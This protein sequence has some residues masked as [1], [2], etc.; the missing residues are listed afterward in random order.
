MRI[1]N[2][3][4]AAMVDFEFQPGRLPKQLNEHREWE[5]TDGANPAWRESGGEPLNLLA[6]DYQQSYAW[7]WSEPDWLMPDEAP[8]FRQLSR[9]FVP[10]PKCHPEVTGVSVLL[11]R[12]LGVGVA[13]FWISD[14]TEWKN[15]PWKARNA[16]R[17]RE[18]Y[19]QGLV[20]A[21]DLFNDKKV[22]FGRNYV[23]LAV[24]LDEE[25]LT[26]FCKNNAD[27]VAPWLTAAYENE[28]HKY[29]ANLIN[30]ER[31]MSW[32][33]HECLFMRWTDALALYNL[34]TV[35]N[36]AYRKELC[37]KALSQDPGKQDT[38]D[39]EVEQDKQHPA[40]TESRDPDKDYRLHRNRAAQL[41]EHCVLARRIFRTYG[42]QIATLS[43]RTG[44][45]RSAPVV[46]HS[47]RRANAVLSSFNEAELDFVV[48]VPIRSIEAGELVRTAIERCAIQ[49]VIDETRRNYDLLDRRL[50]WVRGQWLAVLAVLVFIANTVITI[51]KR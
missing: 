14:Y 6:N 21:S 43:T 46:S 49:S 11:L 51:L 18:C 2:V 22:S 34:D 39:D 33:Q 25:N 30:P 15:D 31:N 1:I 8:L 40:E 32:R 10:A 50:Q 17:R 29:R 37:R 9:W 7:L 19:W 42:Q 36:E 24:R 47:W 27:S 20:A 26:A 44:I 38:A 3:E 16:L 48:S 13:T 5:E 28:T 35:K 23:F 4:A 12:K 45:V 41:F